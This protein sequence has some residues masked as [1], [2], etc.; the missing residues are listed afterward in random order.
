MSGLVV[1]VL[2]GIMPKA[3]A[4]GS[5]GIYGVWRLEGNI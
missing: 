5:S 3:T 1:V 2:C 4:C